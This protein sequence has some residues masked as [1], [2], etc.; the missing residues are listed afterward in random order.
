MLQRHR[1]LPP[2]RA[3]KDRHRIV[4]D[5]ERLSLVRRSTVDLCV[6][7][8]A[9]PSGLEAWLDEV[10]RRWALSVDLRGVRQPSFDVEALVAAAPPGPWRDE[11]AQDLARLLA[12]YVAVVGEEPLRMQ[13]ATVD[14]RKCP[15]FHV[16][17]VGV[18][19]LCTY[20][21][22]ATEWVPESSVD[23]EHLRT[24]DAMHAPTRAGGSVEHLE[25]F[26]VALMKGS[27]FPGNGRFGTVHRSPAVQGAPRLVFT[28]DTLR[29]PGR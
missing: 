5:A 29:V 22:A 26:D 15:R 12:R 2:R 7:R 1:A 23:R 8:R 17:N 11:W 4:T 3:P 9:M 24:C 19:L 13:L 25:R 6:W 20:A 16:D 28:V 21:G 10:A 27:A 18:R 14:D